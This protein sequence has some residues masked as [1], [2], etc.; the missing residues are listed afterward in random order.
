MYNLPQ[1]NVLA[2]ASSTKNGV[3]AARLMC[4]LLQVDN[5]ST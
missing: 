1:F 3:A 5:H 4:Q 2:V